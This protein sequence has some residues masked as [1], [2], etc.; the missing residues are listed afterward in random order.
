MDYIAKSFDKCLIQS[1]RSEIKQVICFL[2]DI[3][4]LVLVIDRNITTSRHSLL[5]QWS[6]LDR[7]LHSHLHNILVLVDFHTVLYHILSSRQTGL[8]YQQFCSRKMQRTRTLIVFPH[9]KLLLQLSRR[10]RKVVLRFHVFRLQLYL[11]T[12]LDFQLQGSNHFV[13]QKFFQ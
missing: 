6:Q 8:T 13:N 9:A 5:P 2:S 4:K 10:I 12:Q 11:G 1:S 7:I 3:K